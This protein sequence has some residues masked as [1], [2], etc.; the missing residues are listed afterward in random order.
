M[1]SGY[2]AN[3]A[4]FD[5]LRFLSTPSTFPCPWA[6]PEL[7]VFKLPG[8]LLQQ[9]EGSATN[10]SRFGLAVRRCYNYRLVSKGELGSNPFRLSFLFKNN[11]KQTKTQN[12]TKPKRCG[13]WTRSCVFVNLTVTETLKWLSSLPSLMP[14]EAYS[15]GVTV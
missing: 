11:T 2:G 9:T 5:H 6:T 7:Q 4:V 14:S 8:Q 13:L 12:Q 15:T 1:L 10:V 3:G